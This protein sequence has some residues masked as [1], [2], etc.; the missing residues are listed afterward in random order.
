MERGCN[1]VELADGTCKDGAWIPVMVGDK[2]MFRCPRRP[3]KDNPDL[4]RELFRTYKAYAKGMLPEA[5]GLQN[6]PAALMESFSIIDGTLAEI[7]H[8]K[9]K[10]RDTSGR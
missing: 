7:E 6:Q 8:Q 4:Y 10:A 2:Q 3:I 1:A 9:N 5:G